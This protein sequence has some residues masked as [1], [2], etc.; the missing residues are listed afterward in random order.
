[1]TAL[2]E[3][4]RETDVVDVAIVG[5]GPVGAAL[6]TLLAQQGRRVVVLERWA[7]PYPLPRAVH[8]DHEAGRI[9]QSCGIGEALAQDQRAGRHLRV[10][11]RRPPAAGAVRARRHRP[12]GL[13][14]VVH[15]HP[16]RARGSAVRT[17]RRALRDR[18][19]PRCPGRRARRRR[20]RRHRARR[21]S[22]HRAGRQRR[23]ADAVG[24]RGAGGPGPLRRRLRRRQ[25]HRAEPDRPRH[26]RPRLLLRLAHRRRDLRRAPHLRPAQRAD[27][28]PGPPDH[29]RVG[30]TR[31][32]P[33]GV[34]GAARRVD[35]PA[36]RRDH[37]VATPRTV[38]RQPRQRPPRT[39]RRLPV[40]SPLGDAMA[41]RARAA[42]R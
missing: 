14:A 9:L 10:P 20:R 40:P 34:H 8:F 24:W 12:V 38:G 16:A 18:R 22:R 17:R 1:M 6:A 37:R 4:A 31:T 42:R 19:A 25:Q 7:E 35:R 11:E 3:R 2:T 30:R 41:A 23:P 13:A 36:Q 28:R 26:D 27:L 33:L 5:Y 15:V 32:A 29:L 39:S 21:T